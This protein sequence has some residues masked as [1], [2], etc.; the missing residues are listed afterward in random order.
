[1]VRT[2]HTYA[3]LEISPEAYGE[4][5]GKLSE[6]GYDHAFDDTRLDGELIDMHGIALKAA[7][8]K[9]SRPATA[10]LAFSP[11]EVP[12]WLVDLI[13][14]FVPEDRQAAAVLAFTTAQAEV[15]P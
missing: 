12:P 14:R 9:L 15:A 5:R 3:V 11:V 7:V 2:T 4:I 10:A 6:A 1:M 8:P 13:T